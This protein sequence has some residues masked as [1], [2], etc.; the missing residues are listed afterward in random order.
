MYYLLLK[1][2]NYTSARNY[3]IKLYSVIY[4]KANARALGLFLVL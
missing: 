2:V 1:A 4:L 3:V